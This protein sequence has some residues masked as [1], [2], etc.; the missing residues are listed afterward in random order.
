MRR[1][2]SLAGHVADISD[3]PATNPL[4]QSK[5][6]PNPAATSAVDGSNRFDTE[7][8]IGSPSFTEDGAEKSAV[9][10]T[11][12]ICTVPLYSATPPSLSLTFARTA[13]VPLSDVGQLEF[14]DDESGE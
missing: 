14:D 12:V 5:A 10:A 13:R 8:M 3:A 4:P 11:F 9:G 7:S 1:P 2:R 6:M